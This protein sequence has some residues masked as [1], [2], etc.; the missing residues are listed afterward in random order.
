VH[1]GSS[2][3]GRNIKTSNDKDLKHVMLSNAFSYQLCFHTRA[4]S[5]FVS[6]FL[7]FD[8]LPI[9]CEVFF[10]GSVLCSQ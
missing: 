7:E 2:Y 1:I 3:S 10:G 4:T 9:A 8:V 6:A 5:A